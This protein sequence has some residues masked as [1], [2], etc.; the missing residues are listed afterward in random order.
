MVQMQLLDETLL[1]IFEPAQAYPQANYQ[2]CD[3]LH[4]AGV[5]RASMEF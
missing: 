3:G 5:K 4:F 1:A 2:F